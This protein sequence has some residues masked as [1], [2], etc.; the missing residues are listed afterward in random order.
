MSL[1]L[2]LLILGA[3]AGGV[4]VSFARGKTRVFQGVVYGLLVGLA[5]ALLRGVI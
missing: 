3:V 4:A 5:G 1:D 2:F